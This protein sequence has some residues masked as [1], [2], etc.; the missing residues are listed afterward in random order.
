M[1]RSGWMQTPSRQ[2][3]GILAISICARSALDFALC[4]L[5]TGGIQTLYSFGSDEPDPPPQPGAPLPVMCFRPSRR[6]HS[7]KGRRGFSMESNVR[8]RAGRS[9]ARLEGVFG[10]LERDELVSVGK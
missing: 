5:E 7:A 4:V 2:T 10:L 8:R 6:S 3:H 1:W 9:F